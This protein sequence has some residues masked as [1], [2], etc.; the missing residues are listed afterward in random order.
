MNNKKGSNLDDTSY[1]KKT[2]SEQDEFLTSTDRLLVL[3]DGVIAIAITLLAIT[4]IQRLHETHGDLWEMKLDFYQYSTG[5]LSLGMYWMLHHHIFNFIK[6]ANGVLMWL[7][8]VFLALASMVPFWV[9]FNAEN[10]EVL[11]E[12]IIP[13]G[14]AMILTFVSL[15]IIWFYA[16]SNHRLVTHDF[17]KR[18]RNGYSMIIAIG[19]AIMVVGT[20]V[21]FYLPETFG[22]FS[23]VAAVWL[24]YMTAHGYKRYLRDKK[25]T[26]MGLERKFGLTDAVI[27]IA[28]TLL[29]LELAIP[30]LNPGS[31][32]YP[33]GEE[34]PESLLDMVDDFFIVAIGFLSLGFYWI[35]HHHLFN[36][37]KRADG[38]LM[39]LNIILLGFA[40]LVPFWIALLNITE[41]DNEVMIYYG[42]AVTL[43]VLILLSIWLY[44]IRNH[45]LIS[46]D[47]GIS[48][49][50]GFTKLLVFILV[51]TI[52]VIIGT[53]FIPG[54]KNIS[55]IISLVLFIYLSAHGYKRFIKSPK[56]NN[57]VEEEEKLEYDKEIQE[58]L[59][60]GKEE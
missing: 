19:A 12:T 33:E 41:G 60:K 13:M 45:R 5:F 53:I 35:M 4:L 55:W 34:P 40:S 38:V 9:A 51:F 10:L 3:T 46:S 54:F 37:I 28:I 47:L 27:S 59:E 24:I 30:D 42:V 20:V 58:E 15:L 14:T 26:W 11:E 21:G 2:G 52:I 8:I 44:A 56:A 31:E 7:N 25:S 36:Y 43:T 49:I 39:W 16:T 1:I 32:V 50:T 57:F 29:V 18:V 17:N 6:K 23:I 48:T 22:I